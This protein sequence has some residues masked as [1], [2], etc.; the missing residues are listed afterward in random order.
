MNSLKH[1]LERAYQQTDEEHSVE[2]PK[3]EHTGEAASEASMRVAV[4]VMILNIMML[5]VIVMIM[6]M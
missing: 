2:G 1:Q 4:N 6:I 5:I 3:A